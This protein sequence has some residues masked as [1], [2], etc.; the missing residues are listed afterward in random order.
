MAE[1]TDGAVGRRE[2]ELQVQRL[3]ENLSTIS[4]NLTA[5][6]KKLDPIHDVCHSEIPALK[7][8]VDMLE[9][10]KDSFSFWRIM[11]YIVVVGGA[12]KA[13]DYFITLIY[14]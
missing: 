13:I 14:K 5:I 6:N 11:G 9:R 7:T 8:K 4:E 1:V 10:F 12:F 3:D 2:Y